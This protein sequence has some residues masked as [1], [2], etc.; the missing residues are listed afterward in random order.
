MGEGLAW[1]VEDGTKVRVG[2]DPGVGI[3]MD[4]KLPYNMIEPLR[5]RG[6][7]KLSQIVDHGINNLWGQG[8]LSTHILGFKGNYTHHG[9]CLFLD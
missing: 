3:C 5:D 6:L 2:E 4:S 9:G 7:Y 1:N 8:S